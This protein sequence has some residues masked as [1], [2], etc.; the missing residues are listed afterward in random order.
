MTFPRLEDVQGEFLDKPCIDFLGDSLTYKADGASSFAPISGFVD[1][2]DQPQDI[3]NGQIIAQDIS[4]EILI[5]DFP[6]RPNANCR[7]TIGRIPGLTF[8]PINIGRDKSGAHWSFNLEKV[9]V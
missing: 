5:A 3:G 9:H 7:I 6:V 1:F 2:S 8:K 4:V